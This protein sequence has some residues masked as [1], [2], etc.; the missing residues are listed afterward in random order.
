M[1]V[2]PGVRLVLAPNPGPMS[3]DGTQSYVLGPDGDCVVVDPGPEDEAHLRLLAGT[4][5]RLILVTHRHAD[6]TAGVDRLHALTGA[7]VQA[8]SA[9]FCRAA[10]P[11]HDGQA[12]TAGEGRL[13]V[14]AT[15][16]HTSDSLS[17]HWETEQESWLLSGDTILG[18]GTTMIDHPDGTLGDYLRSLERL[19]ALAETAKGTRVLPAHGGLG[20]ELADVVHEYRDHR[21]ARLAEVRAAVAQLGD[22]AGAVTALVYSDVPPG[23]LPAARLSIEAQLR[24]LRENSLEATDSLD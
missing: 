9:R 16:G 17:F 14:L 20:R 8:A 21:L 13:T 23:V 22:D 24:Y 1:Q 5:P 7:P 18:T 12:V 10:E 6:H 19:A 4:R 11:L 15:P 3:L 2:A